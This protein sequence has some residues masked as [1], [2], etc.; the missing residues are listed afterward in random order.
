MTDL[1]IPDSNALPGTVLDPYT[2]FIK[3]TRQMSC[4]LRNLQGR[5][6]RV[7]AFHN[8]GAFV[9]ERGAEERSPLSAQDARRPPRSGWRLLGP[10]PRPARPAVLRAGR[11]PLRAASGGGGGGMGR[12]GPRSQQAQSRHPAGAGASSRAPLLPGPCRLAGVRGG[13]P[14]FPCIRK[15]RGYVTL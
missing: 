8:Q 12:A 14:F 7:P 5:P 1:A 11:S 4:P 6:T 13:H 15:G 9:K 10:R 2:V 3:R